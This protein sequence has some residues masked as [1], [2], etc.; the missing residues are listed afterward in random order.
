MLYEVITNL[1]FALYTVNVNGTGLQ[2]FFDIAGKL[3]LNAALLLPLTR[4]PI[5][6]DLF[7]SVSNELPPT[8]D[9][10]TW[11]K[12]GGFRFDCLNMFTNG[13]VDVPMQ[14]APPVTKNARIQFSYNFV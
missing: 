11:Y 10:G 3:E 1:D 12:N 8:L 9:P 13:P 4:P 5:L 6:T 2:P 14:E 7:T